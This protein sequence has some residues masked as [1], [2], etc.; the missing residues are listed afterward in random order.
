MKFILRNTSNWK[1]MRFFLEVF[2]YFRIPLGITR[3]PCMDVIKF[4]ELAA[5]CHLL[6]IAQVYFGLPAKACGYA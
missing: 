1:R 2:S 5:S 3:L 4:F 6:F